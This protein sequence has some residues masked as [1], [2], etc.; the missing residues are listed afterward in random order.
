MTIDG[1]SEDIVGFGGV[2]MAEDGTGGARLPEAR[3]RRRARVRLAVRRRAVAGADPGRHRRALR[4]E[5]AADRRGRTAGELIVVW[6]TPF[7]TE[8]GH[9]VYELLGA[10]SAPGARASAR[11]MIVDPNIGDG[12]GHEPRAR[13]ELDRP[14]RRRLPGRRA[15]HEPM[16]LLR[17]GDVVESVRVASLQRRTVVLAGRDQ[18]RPGALDAAADGSQRAPDR[19]RPDGQRR[20]SSGRSPKSTA[21]RASGRGGSSAQ[22][23]DYVMPVTATSYN[24]RAD[25]QRRGRAGRRDLASSD[26][27]RSPTARRTA[28]GSPLP[29]PRIFLNI[30]PDG[31]SENGAAVPRRWRRRH[32]GVGGGRR[33]RSGARAST[34][35]NAA[36]ACCCTTATAGRGWSRAPSR[37]VLAQSRSVRRSSGSL[38]GPAANSPRPSA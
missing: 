10:S 22:S 36:N 33:R 21:S 9:P 14:G 38:L 11:P 20:S 2:A 6:A 1:P 7:A 31:E 29:G 32:L 13:G 24:G 30:L 28:A 19:D 8:H 37:G 26:R 4:G 23:L 3:R 18:P 16:P 27:P 5:L 25:R 12:D 34:S 17:P 35:T 15:S